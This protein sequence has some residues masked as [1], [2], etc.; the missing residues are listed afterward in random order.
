VKL[1]QEGKTIWQIF[2]VLM[3]ML[4]IVFLAAPASALAPGSNS[5]AISSTPGASAI[6]TTSALAP[7]SNS[8]AKS[9][10]SG[11]IVYPIV[12]P[13]ALNA[14]TPGP[15]CAT[16]CTQNARSTGYTNQYET[17]IPIYIT[18]INGVTHT[19]YK[20]V[21][22]TVTGGS[23]SRTCTPMTRCSVNKLCEQ[24]GDP[25]TEITGKWEVSKEE[26]IYYWW[27]PPL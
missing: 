21:R 12:F 2:I 24:S 4:L 14:A 6:P 16:T 23:N 25:Y 5:G 3:M 18:V 22:V 13:V 17:N 26:I 15:Q 19:L 27:N 11:A 7:G 10:S 9:S 1:R 8:A 20:H